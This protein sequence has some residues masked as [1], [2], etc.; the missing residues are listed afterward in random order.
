[1]NFISSLKKNKR[2]YQVEI[3]NANVSPVKAFCQQIEQNYPQIGLIESKR[4]EYA[5]QNYKYNID[6]FNLMN[7]QFPK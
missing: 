3:L 2:V 1:M 6:S 7:K 4:A 5:C